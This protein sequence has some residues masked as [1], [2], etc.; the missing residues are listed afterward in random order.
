MD[1]MPLA[2]VMQMPTTS[3]VRS[4]LPDN[5]RPASRTLFFSNCRPQGLLLPALATLWIMGLRCP[6]S[7]GPIFFRPD[8][9][10]DGVGRVHLAPQFNDC[11]FASGVPAL[12]APGGLS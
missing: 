10:R 9:R 2:G 7:V 3:V 5:T 1:A 6:D 8:S 12:E 11:I 4:E